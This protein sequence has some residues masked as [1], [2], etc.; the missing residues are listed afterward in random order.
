MNAT[1]RSLSSNGRKPKV[2]KLEIN[3]CEHCAAQIV[4]D[5]PFGIIAFPMK[6]FCSEECL[7]A[8]IEERLKA[9]GVKS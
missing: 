7:K 3:N 5:P 6:V 4:G 9:G 8:E 1:Q 2:V